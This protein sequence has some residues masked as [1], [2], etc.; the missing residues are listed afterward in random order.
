MSETDST[1]T[2]SSALSLSSRRKRKRNDG[3]ASEA[4]KPNDR[5]NKSHTSFF[6]RKDNNDSEIAYCLLCERKLGAGK[7]PYPYSRK[8]G[9]TSNLSAH[10]R[11]KHGITR[12]N[13]SEYLD[14]NN[15]VKG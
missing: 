13:F 3:E 11:D 10:L 15:E 8:G 5:I 2:P 4:D 9:S 12:S 7:T 6:F 1:I 14:G